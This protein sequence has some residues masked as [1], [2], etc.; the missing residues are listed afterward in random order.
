MG[1][2]IATNLAGPIHL[3][4]AALPHLRAQGSGPVIQI[5]SYGGQV[6]YP[7]N[8]MYHATKWGIEGFVESV[9]LEVGPSESA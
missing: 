2:I 9:A 7:G 8:S 4:R 5:S 3:I 6:A 1:H